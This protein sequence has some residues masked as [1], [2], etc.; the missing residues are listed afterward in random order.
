MYRK[1][2]IM[3]PGLESARSA[4]KLSMT[5]SAATRTSVRADMVRREKKVYINVT[6]KKTLNPA[7]KSPQQF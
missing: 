7:A 1:S 3:L 6:W 5:A 4:K 2:L